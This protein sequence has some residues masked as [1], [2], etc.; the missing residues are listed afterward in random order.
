MCQAGLVA[1]TSHLFAANTNKS[2]RVNGSLEPFVRW[3]QR[4]LCSAEL[5][6][7]LLQHGRATTSYRLPG[8]KERGMYLFIPALDVMS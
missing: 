8:N 1:L 3:K 4:S 6:C 5:V 7:V 2:S